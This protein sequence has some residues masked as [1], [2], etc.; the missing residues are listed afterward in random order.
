M[1]AAVA[2][3][4]VP[5]CVWLQAKLETL[6]DADTWQAEDAGYDSEAMKNTLM[7]RY[8]NAIPGS[9]RVVA[10]GGAASVVGASAALSPHVT[11]AQLHIGRQLQLIHGALKDIGDYLRIMTGRE[12]AGSRG[13]VAAAATRLLNSD[14]EPD[15]SGQLRGTARPPCVQGD[16][17]SVPCART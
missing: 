8:P 16:Q 7:S 17:G 4:C 2:A 11:P 3:L 5:L 10:K 6:C 12:T 14:A 13:K 15:E 1:D 9:V